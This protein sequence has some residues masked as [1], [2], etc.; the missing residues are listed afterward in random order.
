MLINRKK[1]HRNFNK[2]R[3]SFMEVREKHN[4]DL[5]QRVNQ[6]QELPDHAVN[7]DS[8]ANNYDHQ[9]IIQ[10]L[11][12]ATYCTQEIYTVI[13]DTSGKDELRQLGHKL[14]DVNPMVA[15]DIFT[16]TEDREAKE[17][18]K[19]NLFTSTDPQVQAYT[20][21]WAREQGNQTLAKYAEALIAN[22]SNPLLAFSAG[23]YLGRVDI[24]S[25]AYRQVEEID[26]GRAQEIKKRFEALRKTP[27]PSKANKS[28]VLS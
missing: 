4:Q 9:G 10:K 23:E 21:F 26:A 8:A 20:Y 22:K 24:A 15:M 5:E 17:G 27:V 28:Q 12:K 13:K 1:G 25:K 2:R 19:K 14:V 6:P 3:Q 7:A 11:G 18:L 16:Y